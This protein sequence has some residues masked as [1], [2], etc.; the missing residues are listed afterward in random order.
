MHLPWKPM[1]AYSSSS[2]SIIYTC[3]FVPLNVRVNQSK[4]CLFS[5][6]DIPIKYIQIKR[7]IKKLREDLYSQ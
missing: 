2:C 5:K 1:T 7:K 4:Y 3:L 6:R